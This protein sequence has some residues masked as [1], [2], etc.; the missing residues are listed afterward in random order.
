LEFYDQVSFLKAGLVF[1][2][3]LTT[4]SPTY[5]HEIQGAEAGNGLHGLLLH[6]SSALHGILNGID[7]HEWD[8]A[9]DKHLPTHFSASNLRGKE[10]CARALLE[11][12][13]LPLPKSATKRPPIFGSVGRLVDQKGVELIITALPGALDRGAMAVIVGSGEAQYA[14]ALRD[15]QKRYPQQLAVHIGFSEELAHLVEAGADFFLMPSRFE[16]CGLN[17]MY[18]LRYG[19]VPIVRGVG[20]LEDTVVDLSQPDANGIKF[21]PFDTQSMWSAIERAL[22]LWSKPQELKAV[23]QRGMAEDNS[24]EHSAAQY[25]RLYAQLTGA[26]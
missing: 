9:A 21:G 2:D 22:D 16:P 25:E 7:V 15:L 10:A 20:G 19:T 3:A 26:P 11:R 4:V 14:N 1:A 24:W 17:Q 13:K 18:S 5:A 23:Q 12:M 8:P 6:R